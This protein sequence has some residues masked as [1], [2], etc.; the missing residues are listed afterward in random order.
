MDPG[1]KQ[2][3]IRQRLKS[4]GAIPDI[5]NVKKKSQEGKKTGGSSVKKKKKEDAEKL[6]KATMTAM[7]MSSSLT[8]WLKKADTPENEE[9][10]VQKMIKKH[11]EFRLLQENEGQSNPTVYSTKIRDG[12]SGRASQDEEHAGEQVHGTGVDGHVAG[13]D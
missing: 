3:L 5:K 2:A 7:K 13:G 12:E 11:E 8:S 4:E 6:K 1:L 9:F 10:S